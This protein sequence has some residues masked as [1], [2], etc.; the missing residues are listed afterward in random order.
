M[1]LHCPQCRSAEV[2]RLSLVYR[3]GTSEVQ[4]RSGTIGMGATGAGLG[5]GFASTVTQGTHQSLLAIDT[6]PPQKKSVPL[7]FF[8]LALGLLMIAAGV[9]GEG[10][11]F[12]VLGPLL[13]IIGWWYL[14]A[15]RTFNKKYPQLLARWEASF[16]CMRCGRVF[17]AANSSAV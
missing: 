16:L 11:A 9:S 1:E 14:K 13:S 8:L 15:A 6:A 17:Q 2:R 4:T 10:V 7:A 12:L 3:A 5:A